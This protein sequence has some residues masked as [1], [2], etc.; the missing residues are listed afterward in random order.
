MWKLVLTA[1]N[2]LLTVYLMPM[3]TEMIRPRQAGLNYQNQEVP[4]GLGLVF[5]LTVVPTT[6]LAVF[7]AVLP[8]RS[9]VIYIITILSFGLLGI[10]DDTIGSREARGFTG[11]FRA[12]F[13]GFLTTGAIKALFGVILAFL[14]AVIKTDSVLSI[15]LNV[16][17]ITLFANLLNLL[18]VRPGRASKFYLFWFLFS[19]IMGYPSI[20]MLF[21]LAAVIGYL[22]WDLQ[23]KVM[24]GDV[25]SNVLGAIIGL[26][27]TDFSIT[28][29]VIVVIVLILIHLYAEQTSLSLLIEKTPILKHLD[30]LGRKKV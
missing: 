11:H 24:M 5:I 28:S 19:Y 23:A 7:F 18:D 9:G 4:V 3:L 1:I 12:L 30:N 25:G 2:F 17:S 16:L 14:V 8:L 26:S 22:P 13:Q 6:I 20:V 21:L 29:K 10:I 15:I 27:V